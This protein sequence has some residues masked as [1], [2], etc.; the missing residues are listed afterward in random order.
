MQKDFELLNAFLSGEK[1]AGIKFRHNSSVA[2][3]RADGTRC[4][5]WIVSLTL[6]GPEPVYTVECGDGSGDV[7]VLESKLELI[8]AP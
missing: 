7:D 4:L 1:I 6:N 5:G 3:I 8:A 2:F